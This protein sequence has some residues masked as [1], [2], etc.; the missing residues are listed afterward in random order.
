M[1]SRQGGSP[2]APGRTARGEPDTGPDH[3]IP[4]ANP[5]PRRT[6]P[7]IPAPPRAAGIV[8]HRRSVHPTATPNQHRTPRCRSARPGA[9]R[10]TPVPPARI[11]S[12]PPSYPARQPPASTWRRCLRRSS[13]TCHA[14]F[15]RMRALSCIIASSRN[16]RIGV[17]DTL[18]PTWKGS[19]KAAISDIL[20]HLPKLAVSGRGASWATRRSQPRLVPSNRQT[21]TVPATVT[22]YYLYA[23]RRPRTAQGMSLLAPC[24][25]PNHLISNSAIFRACE[26]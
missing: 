9:R 23:P 18:C 1:W 6:R 5:A 20:S 10:S 26:R 8:A 21:T 2:R 13:W 15:A 22:S 12:E 4:D 11:G 3:P 24:H 7:P 14:G 16:V 25:H 19:R 17:T